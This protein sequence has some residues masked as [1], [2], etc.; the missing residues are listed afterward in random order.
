[1][2]PGDRDI[3][4]HVPGSRPSTAPQRDHAGLRT[5]FLTSSDV[6][7]FLAALLLTGLFLAPANALDVTSDDTADEYLISGAVVIDAS[8]AD[9]AGAA[10]C[11]DCHWRIVAI[12]DGG[13]LD[14]RRGCESLDLVC[15]ARRAEV[16]RAI[17]VET[18]PIGDPSWEYRGVSCLSHAPVSV[19]TVAQ[20][21]P[22]LV[23]KAVPILRAGSAPAG[24]TLTNFPTSFF[25]GQSA[26]HSLS[27]AIVEGSAVTLHLQPQWRWDFGHGQPITTSVPGSADKSSAIA[28][29]FPRRGL[30]RVRV[31]A[32]WFA[33]YDINGVRG[34]T[35]PDPISQS[36]VFDIRVRE[37]RRFLLSRRST[38]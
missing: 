20:T 11:V 3:L 19:A 25:T 12:C 36:M 8:F 30:Y 22:E 24:T 27:P 15:D 9:T 35:A 5:P 1:M 6:P 34:F 13:S 14:D 38:E 18:P 33:T 17:A 10:N 16:W 26:A 23:R 37:A 32:T 21:I 28:H 7:K 2:R 31:D 29:R 4:C